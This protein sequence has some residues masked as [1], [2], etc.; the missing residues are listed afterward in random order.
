MSLREPRSISEKISVTEFYEA[1][2]ILEGADMYSQCNVALV[3][4]R[5]CMNTPISLSGS[6]S[7]GQ[8]ICISMIDFVYQDLYDCS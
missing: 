5:P 3:L 8:L 2:E 7:Q 6:E 1:V 4:S